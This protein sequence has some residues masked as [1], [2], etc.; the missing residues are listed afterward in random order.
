ARKEIGEQGGMGDPDRAPPHR[1]GTV[2]PLRPR[3]AYS[4]ERPYQAELLVNQRITSRDSEKDVRHIELCLEGSGLSYQPGDALGVW[5]V[6][7]N[8]LVDQVL[9]TLGL[10]GEEVVVVQDAS[11]PLRDWLA[12]HRELTQITRPFLIAHAQRA[13]STELSEILQPE[14][15]RQLRQLLE[16]RQLID[17][18]RR[19]PAAWSANE[20]VQA[21][22]PLGPR[23]YSIASSA[24][25]V[26]EEVHLT[27]ANVAFELEGEP[28]WGVASNYLSRLEEGERLPIFIEDNTRFRLPENPASDIIMIGP[29]T[30]VAPFR[31]FVQHRAESEAAGRNWLFFGNPHFASD[32]LYQTEWQ[33]VLGEGRLHRL[34]LAFS[35]DQEEKRYV[36]HLLWEQRSEVYEWLQ[37]GAYLYVCGDATHMARDVHETLLRI[38]GHEGQMEE[39]E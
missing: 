35:R 22:R 34:D 2:T 33:R 14:G 16:T 6:Q 21:L 5:P 18:L 13:G 3:P 1:L 19:W 38:A 24:A 26:G 32:F 10:Q 23:L 20:C 7:A 36:Q 29:G 27:V 12:Q 28:R 39:A 25:A 9:G 17:V 31:A 8:E 15:A 4:R 37:A 11:R 30:G